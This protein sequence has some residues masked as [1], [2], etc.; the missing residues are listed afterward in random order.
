MHSP[1]SLNDDG[2][3]EN[4]E[5]RE[6]QGQQWHHFSPEGKICKEQS[7]PQAALFLLDLQFLPASCNTMRF[8]QKLSLFPGAL[9][10]IKILS[11]VPLPPKGRRIKTDPF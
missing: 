8:P 6:K 3:K 9:K 5:C 11:T 1:E 2:A 7:G 4:E 10:T